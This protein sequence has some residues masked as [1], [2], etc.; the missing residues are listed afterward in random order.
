V[1]P[2]LPSRN[3][4]AVSS[5][6]PDVSVFGVRVELARSGPRSLVV[7]RNLESGS[8]G[9][10]WYEKTALSKSGR[11]EVCCH[12]DHPKTGLLGCV[13]RARFFD[14]NEIH[15]FRHGRCETNELQKPLRTPRR[16]YTSLCE[17]AQYPRR[18]LGEAVLL[19]AITIRDSLQCRNEGKRAFPGVC[20]CSGDHGAPCTTSSSTL[21]GSPPVLTMWVE[22]LWSKTKPVECGGMYD[23]VHGAFLFN[24]K[25][26]PERRQ[27]KSS[28]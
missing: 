28:Q 5:S 16:A 22:P 2:V 26:A 13:E 15:A 14:W 9:L 23:V 19:L 10:G 17:L 3:V 11:T 6:S 8:G 4:V 1:S 20:A 24:F 7:T 18:L 21:R 25:C 12:R 27:L